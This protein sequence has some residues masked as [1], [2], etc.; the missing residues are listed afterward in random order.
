MKGFKRWGK[1]ISAGALALTLAALLGAASA[2]AATT[3][4]VQYRVYYVAAG[5]QNDWNSWLHQMLKNYGYAQTQPVAQ[6]PVATTSSYASQVVAMVNQERAKAGLKPLAVN[7]KLASMALVKA[8]DMKNNRYFD[9]NSP[10]Y[11]SPFDMMKS[12]GITYRYAGENI[13]MGQ[14]NPREVMT[15][16]MNS[17]GH[18]ANILNANYSSIGVAYY[19]GEWV[20]EF[21]G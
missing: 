14:R 17:P 13:A 5:T 10:T 21:I 11:G 7:A 2:S 6:H 16:W 4:A 1:R 20:Q 8:K 9:H 19:N 18:K 3:P 15:A 12:F